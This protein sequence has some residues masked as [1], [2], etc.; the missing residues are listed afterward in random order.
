MLP[1]FAVYSTFLQRGYDELIHD[2][3][4]QNA[5]IVL[6]IDRAGL[7]GEDGET[8]QGVFDAAFLNTIPNVT[9][10]APSFYAELHWMLKKAVY[11]YKG[12][13]AVR[14][15]RGGEPVPPQGYT[16]APASYSL[17]GG[18]AKVLLITYGRIF[19]NACKARES[20]A[21]KGI[22]MDILKLNRIKPMGSPGAVHCPGIS[23]GFFLRRRHPYRRGSGAFRFFPAFGRI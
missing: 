17:L 3:A 18:G 23:E 8:H 16:P 19:A 22:E 15:P 7:V 4:L 1:V 14:Y 13:V 10:F 21:Q 9:V 2:A 20:L 6:C 5:K 11:Q 12:V